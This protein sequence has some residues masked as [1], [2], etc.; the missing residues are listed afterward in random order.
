MDVGPPPVNTPPVA[1]ITT[2]TSELQVTADGSTST[3]AD[4]TIVSYAWDFGDGATA[5]GATPAA[6]T[7]AAAG[8]YT[9]G[10]TVTDDDGATHTTTKPVT[11][12]TTPP[13]NTPPVARI[14][15][16]TSELQV[17]A[18]GST[19]TDA[20]GTIVSYAWDFGDGATATG[21]TPAA[22]TYAA[23]G[24]YTVGLTVTDDD[25]ATHTTTKPVTVT[26]TP[27]VNTLAQDTFDRSVASGW[28]TAPTGGAWTTT[29]S[30][31]LSVS[32]GKG[33]VANATGSTRTAYLRTVSSSATQ[34]SLTLSPDKVTTGGGL[35]VSVS[36][37]A[38]T[39]AGEYR[40]KLRLRSDARADLTLIRT[41]STGVETTLRTGVLVPN[42]TYAAGASIRLRMDV[43]GINPT[44]IR[45][46]AWDAASAEPAGWL[47]S[48]T[49]AT[50][51][52]QVPGAVGLN[53]YYSS[54][55]TN[56]PL[57]LAVDDVA[58]V[59]Q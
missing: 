11:V 25:G 45:A 56:A 57:V 38:I 52:L 32:S 6:H 1:R 28:G 26:T 48:T 40:A 16:T 30:T 36:G 39:G 10:L 2:T 23:A 31:S 46:R 47:V 22:H 18:D 59:V 35:Y 50:A 3:D 34:L 55:A 14:T 13:V 41:S 17:S 12:T 24:T 49:D 7:Y 29:P 58:A 4:G 43:T 21:A 27:P 8:T 42:L 20:D 51:A 53:A 33:R 9:V 54:T 44:T 15:T 37:R 5:T 19:S